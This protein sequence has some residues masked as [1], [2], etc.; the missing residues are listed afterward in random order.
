M[1]LSRLLGYKKT[2]HKDVR[3]MSNKELTEAMAYLHRERIR[4]ERKHR[5]FRGCSTASQ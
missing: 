1:L 2:F 3:N 4:L 5:S